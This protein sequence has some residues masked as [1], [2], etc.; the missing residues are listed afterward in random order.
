MATKVELA[1]EIAE[2]LDMKKYI[3][4]E[5]IVDGLSKAKRDGLIALKTAILEMKEKHTAEMMSAVEDSKIS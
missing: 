5:E 3:C 4:F 2:M 1:E